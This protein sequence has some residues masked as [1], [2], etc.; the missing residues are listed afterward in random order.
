MCYYL[1]TTLT[2]VYCILS[3]LFGFASNLFFALIFSSS[4]MEMVMMKIDSH[5]FLPFVRTQQTFIFSSLV[6]MH[7]I[8]IQ[9][10]VWSR[11]LGC[12]VFQM[13]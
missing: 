8:P 9:L 4:P 10:S 1:S 7:Q 6:I 3:F 12:I 5:W 13:P 11:V 2:S